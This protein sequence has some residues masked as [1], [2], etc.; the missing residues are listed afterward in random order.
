M[1]QFS[2]NIWPPDGQFSV[3]INTY[4]IPSVFPSRGH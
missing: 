3:A 2:V 1:G 4:S